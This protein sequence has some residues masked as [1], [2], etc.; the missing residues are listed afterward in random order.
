MEVSIIITTYGK[1]IYLENCI[2][3]ALNQTFND[4]E[5]II[6][7]D[8][9]PNSNNRK[10]TEVIVYKFKQNSKI[11]YVQHEKNKNGSAARN[12]GI[13]LAKG[14][15]ISFL[16]NDDEYHST[17]LEKC[18]EILNNS[19]K[20]IGG[21]YT[22]CELRKNG[23]K[24][25][26]NKSVKAGNFLI[27]S[28]ACTFL[29]LTGSNM[30]IRSNII[31]ELNG[32]DETFLRHQDYEFLVRFFKKYN[33]ESISEV[34]VIKNNDNFNLPDVNGIILIK[35]KFLKKFDS[36]I[37][38]MNTIDKKYIIKSHYIAIS[39]F[40]LKSKNYSISKEYYSKSKKYGKLT[41]REKIR[42]YLIYL[43]SMLII[44]E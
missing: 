10:L 27:E 29:L 33:F 41:F 36:I 42:K 12:T 34:L 15:Y 13:S 21:V 5:I 38:N 44:N 19:N 23:K 20:N 25:Y 16:D 39:E 22:G 1:P 43:N 6:V 40:A 37:D 31:S 32:F 9:N 14:K 4:Y 35:E 24:Y 8:N 3:S 2:S 28:L 30:F 11:K 7:D 18:F 17:R 26:V